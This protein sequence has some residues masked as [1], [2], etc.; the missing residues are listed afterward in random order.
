MELECGLGDSMRNGTRRP[1]DPD[2][3]A[4]QQ[5]ELRPQVGPW[6]LCTRSLW[7]PGTYA[8]SRPI[9]AWSTYVTYP[10]ERDP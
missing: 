7:A 2:R 9:D 3:R 8:A 10:G 5:S 4:E 1:V 6:K